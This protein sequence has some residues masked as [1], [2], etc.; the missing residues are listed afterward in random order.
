MRGAWAVALAPSSAQRCGAGVGRDAADGLS[1]AS[2]ARAPHICSRVG[3][4]NGVASTGGRSFEG[5]GAPVAGHT[6]MAGDCRGGGYGAA[7]ACVRRAAQPFAQ[8]RRVELSKQGIR[9]PPVAKRCQSLESREGGGGVLYSPDHASSMA[10]VDAPRG[11][12]RA[13]LRAAEPLGPRRAICGTRHV[14]RS[15]RRDSG[16]PPYALGCGGQAD[17]SEAR[18]GI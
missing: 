9:P 16:R 13:C 3:T 15:L 4:C 12:A 17:A 11:R 18:H 6:S 2:T 8:R 5:G 7:A 14:A 10:G 1:C